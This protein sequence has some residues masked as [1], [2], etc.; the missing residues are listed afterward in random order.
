MPTRNAYLKEIQAYMQM[1]SHNLIITSFFLIFLLQ[2]SAFAIE[3]LLIKN[4]WLREAPPT[5]K[6]M[7][8]Y[9]DIENKSDK[10]LVL[11]K[12]ESDEFEHIEFH[13][14]QVK[15]SIARMTQQDT[16]VITPNSTFSFKP[17]SYHLMLFDN[18]FPMREGKSTTI[19]FTF[20]N[21]DTHEF[22][23]PVKISD[24]VDAH[25]HHNHR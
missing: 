2:N 24:S 22:D 16:I 19:K 23:A 6:V 20:D 9:L 12:A 17:E 21:G 5:T 25:Q 4:A 15:D 11:V 14:S 1:K 13:L 7:A 8:G 3:N 10:E 18:K